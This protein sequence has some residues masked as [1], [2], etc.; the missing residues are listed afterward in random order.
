MIKEAAI[1]KNGV[2]FTGRRHNDILCDKSRPFGF[3]RGGE[4]GFI[5]DS[6]VFMNREDAAVLAYF[7]GQIKVP[8]DKLYSEDLY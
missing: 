5:T 8:K 2:V 1:R 4:Q 3:L 7:Y 6:G